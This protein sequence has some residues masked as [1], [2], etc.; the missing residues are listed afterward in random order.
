M[1]QPIKAILEKISSL[2]YQATYGLYER[3]TPVKLMVLAALAGESAFLLGP[4]GV[5]KSLI[6]RRIKHL[7]TDARSFEYLMGKFSTPDELFGPL[8]IEKLTKEDTY[9][10]RVEG[11]LPAAHVVFLDEV[12]NASPPIQNALLTVLNEKKFRNGATEISLPMIL[13]V[14]ASN[15]LHTQEDTKA[16]W[17]RFLLR[18]PMEPIRSIEAFEQ[19]I[20]DLEDP[21]SDHISREHKL[22]LSELETFR[23]HCGSVQIAT[24]VIKLVSNIRTIFLDKGKSSDRRWKKILNLLKASALSHGRTQV[25]MADCYLI[26]FCL[27]DEPEEIEELKETISKEIA[28]SLDQSLS[29]FFQSL[30]QTRFKLMEMYDQVEKNLPQQEIPVIYDGEYVCIDLIAPESNPELDKNPMDPDAMRIWKPDLNGINREEIDCFLYAQGTYVKTVKAFLTPGENPFCFEVTW[31]DESSPTLNLEHKTKGNMRTQ[32]ATQT[33]RE[34]DQLPHGYSHLS[35]ALQLQTR[36]SLE[37]LLLTIQDQKQQLESWYQNLSHYW[38]SF[39]WIPL[40]EE[41][42]TFTSPQQTMEG[43]LKIEGILTRCLEVHSTQNQS[44]T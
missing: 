44:K 3:D 36:P 32:V 11:F 14:G 34:L 2:I 30:D 35:H 5:G 27:W 7:F 18:I 24:G 25:E 37:E 16:F 1:D 12:W 6:A 21:S 8:S 33:R 29:P 28:Q 10:R 19:M 22:S 31:S 13:F 38:S 39:H 4:P 42:A 23:T 9:Q 15:S 26:P 40:Q 17:D 20:L 41:F 43:F